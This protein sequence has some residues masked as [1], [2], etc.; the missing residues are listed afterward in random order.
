M[1]EQG[2]KDASWSDFVEVLSGDDAS[3]LD[4]MR[5]GARGVVSVAANVVPALFRDMGVQASGKNWKKANYCCKYRCD[6]GR[7]NF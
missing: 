4:A 2:D 6:H 1:S 5:H 7:C 3:C